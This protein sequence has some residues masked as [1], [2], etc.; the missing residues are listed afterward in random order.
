MKLIAK[1]N[2]YIIFQSLGF[3]ASLLSTVLIIRGL[4]SSEYGHFSYY[5]ALGDFFKSIIILGFDQSI[6][7]FSEE[8]EVNRGRHDN[9]I[10]NAKLIVFL[11]LLP[12]VFFIQDKHVVLSLVILMLTGLFD[13]SYLHMEKSNLKQLGI[14]MFATR[15]IYL[16]GT[17][18]LNSLG[19][20]YQYYFIYFSFVSVLYTA[21]VIFYNNINI[22]KIK[23]ALPSGLKLLRRCFAAGFCRVYLFAE[24]FLVLNIF[25]TCLSYEKFG[26]FMIIFNVA[27]LFSG[28][29]GIVI[30]PY[31]KKITTENEEK[32]NAYKLLVLLGFFFVA[33]GFGVIYLTPSDYLMA[34][35]KISVSDYVFKIWMSLALMYSLVIFFASVYINIGLLAS[36]RLRIFYMSRLF[37]LVVAVCFTIFLLPEE[38]LISVMILMAS[39]LII[40]SYALACRIKFH[41]ARRED[42]LGL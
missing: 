5:A 6:T 26:Q 10:F 40:I 27:K 41:L 7:N 16:V 15:S 13:M 33:F 31:Y 36:N 12:F 9:E 24:S 29:L 11:V 4:G 30:T 42:W 19:L 28:F 21:L 39:E 35:I 37:Y 2:A 22:C 32:G 34:L 23:L 20:S 17:L 18:I 8:R 25:R 1:L 38:P 14:Y 3:F